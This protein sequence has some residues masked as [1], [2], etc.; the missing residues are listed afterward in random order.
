MA[1]KAET[2]LEDYLY[3]GPAENTIQFSLDGKNCGIGLS[4]TNTGNL[5]KALRPYTAASRNIHPHR[6][7]LN[8]SKPRFKQ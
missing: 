1:P 8:N 6:R 7:N 5:H 4:A 2:H 3:G